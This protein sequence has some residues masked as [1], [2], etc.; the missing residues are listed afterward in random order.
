MS[1]TTWSLYT[2]LKISGKYNSD[3]LNDIFTSSDECLKNNIDQKINTFCLDINTANWLIMIFIIS[4]IFSFL[5][6]FPFF[7]IKKKMI[8]KFKDPFG[9][10]H[11]EESG[12][13]PSPFKIDKEEAL[14]EIKDSLD[15]W[16]Q[17][18]CK[19]IFFTKTS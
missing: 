19:K 3:F 1:L 10:V 12:N 11:G 15:K 14:R 16:D 4:S 18:N 9:G 13:R 8:K 17:K 6:L 7:L 5:T 2:F